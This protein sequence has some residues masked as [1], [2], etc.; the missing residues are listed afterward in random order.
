MS[1]LKRMIV[2]D[3]ALLEFGREVVQS[4]GVG[5]LSPYKRLVTQFRYTGTALLAAIQLPSEADECLLSNVDTIVCLHSTSPKEARVAA[6]M[7]DLPE[8]AIPEILHLPIGVGYVRSAGFSGPIKIWMPNFELGPYAS[9][10]SVAER[11]SNQLRLLE[12]ETIYSPANPEDAA[13]IPLGEILGESPAHEEEGSADVDEATRR[14]FLH[15]HCLLMRDIEQQP[16]ASVTEHYRR[17]KFSAWRG[18]RI[19]AQLVEMGL[20]RSD[21]QTSA[22]GRPREILSLTNKGK[23][24]LEEHHE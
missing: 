19:K 20:I 6:E 7:M 10:A 24:L 18:N 21:R 12:N 11:L 1:E 15:E 22:N 17:L 23:R 2:S 3:E 14:R 4:Y 8:E 13:P 16:S 9:D 5:L